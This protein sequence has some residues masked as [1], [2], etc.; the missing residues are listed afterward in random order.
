MHKPLPTRPLPTLLTKL[1]AMVRAMARR[2]RARR[3]SSR[4]VCIS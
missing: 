4:L 2:V 1:M 3:P